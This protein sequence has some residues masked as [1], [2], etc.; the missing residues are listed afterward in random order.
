MIKVLLPIN[1]NDQIEAIKYEQKD[2]SLLKSAYNKWNELNE[3]LIRLQGRKM[4]FP[5]DLIESIICSRYEMLKI[6]NSS[7]ARFDIWDP[8]AS[9]KKN[10][11]MVQATTNAIFQ[12]HLSESQA[13]EIDRILFVKLFVVNGERLKYEIYDFLVEDIVN[14][15]ETSKISRVVIDYH[16]MESLPKRDKVMG[17]L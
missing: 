1:E 5:S 3:E 12:L 16:K 14:A 9:D 17:E 15:E 7:Y 2:E 6:C 4:I 8:K 11:I 10:R 13:K